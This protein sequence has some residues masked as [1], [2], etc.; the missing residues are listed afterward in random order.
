MV[1]KTMLISFLRDNLGKYRFNIFE[2]LADAYLTLWHTLLAK[3][4]VQEVSNGSDVVFHADDVDILC[5]LKHHY[6]D[7]LSE[8]FFQTFKRTNESRQSL[9]VKD[10]N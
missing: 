3:V 9:R 10:V 2:A 5:L 8:V 4:A 6:E 7:V 1:K